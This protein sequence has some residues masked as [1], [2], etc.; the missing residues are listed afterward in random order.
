MQTSVSWRDR[1]KCMYAKTPQTRFDF[2]VTNLAGLCT[3]R[4]SLTPVSY[5][6]LDV[7]KRQLQHHILIA[8]RR[9]LLF[10]AV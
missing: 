7:Y 4:I 8:G 1:G 2:V 3:T 5:T 9:Q 6:H 10:V